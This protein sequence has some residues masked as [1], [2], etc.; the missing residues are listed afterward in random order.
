MEWPRIQISQAIVSNFTDKLL[1]LNLITSKG[2]SEEHLIT[3]YERN[4][5]GCGLDFT[6]NPDSK[7]DLLRYAVEPGCGHK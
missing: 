6:E 5:V 7:E 4:L 3:F 1:K 2:D